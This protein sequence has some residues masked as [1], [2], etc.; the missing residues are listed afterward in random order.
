MAAFPQA[1]SLPGQ[2]GGI[3][4]KVPGDQSTAPFELPPGITTPDYSVQSMFPQTSPIDGRSLHTLIDIDAMSTGND[5]IPVNA[6]NEVDPTMLASWA[7]MTLSVT[8]GSVGEPESLIRAR[9][10]SPAGVAADAFSFFFEGAGN[11]I[12]PGLEGQTFLEQTAGHIGFDT[13]TPVDMDACDY[14]LPL[15]IMNPTQQGG[16]FCSQF[17][18]FY[19]SLTQA[20]AQEVNDWFP[21]LFGDALHGGDVLRLDWDAGAGQWFA[22]TVYRDAQQLGLTP[23]PTQDDVNALMYDSQT[24]TLIF[25]TD[26]P[27]RARFLVQ[28]NLTTGH[29]TLMRLGGDP[30]PPGIKIQGGDDIDALCGFDPHAGQYSFWLATPE[31]TALPGQELGLSIARSHDL[32]GP[33]PDRAWII[34]SGFGSIRPADGVLEFKFWDGNS[35]RPLWSEPRTQMQHSFGSNQ[36]LPPI[37]VGPA[38]EVRIRVDYRSI[39]GLASS[40][41]VVFKM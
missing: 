25:S 11:L 23:E 37:P 26:N 6:S 39:H 27:T 30:I 8:P 33:M 19:F 3:F 7:A 41:P 29:S 31:S 20:S 18:E 24:N 21:V 28:P 9:S 10:T 38:I 5:K 22:P 14:F 16:P 2:G 13:S 32:F 17:R 15:I 1:I 12:G 4:L 36:P 34:V 40:Y 35:W